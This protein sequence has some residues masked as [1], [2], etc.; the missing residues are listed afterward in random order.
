[1]PVKYG[2]SS[3]FVKTNRTFNVDLDLAGLLNS[4]SEE[5]DHLTFCVEPYTRARVLHTAHKYPKYRNSR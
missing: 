4:Q 5:D 1:M 2:A 3:A